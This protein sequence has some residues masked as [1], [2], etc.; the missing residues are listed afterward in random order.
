MAGLRRWLPSRA[1]RVVASAGG[2]GD[3]VSKF[4]RRPSKAIVTAPPTIPERWNDRFP[5]T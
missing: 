1:E 4:T 5:M 2:A 3:E